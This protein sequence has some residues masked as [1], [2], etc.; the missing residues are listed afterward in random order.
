MWYDP[1]EFRK[2]CPNDIGRDDGGIDLN[3]CELMSGV[4]V[5]GDCV[6]TDG[7]FRCECPPGYKLDST[8]KRCIGT[9][10]NVVMQA[11]T[12][13]RAPIIVHIGNPDNM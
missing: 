12:A 11:N 4:C 9:Y 7:S 3:E 6:N 5:G 2:L 10:A 13:Y 8:G 1:D